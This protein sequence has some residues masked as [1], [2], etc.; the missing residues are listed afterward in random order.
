MTGV[1]DEEL[2]SAMVRLAE[3]P[4]TTPAAVDSIAD[5]IAKRRSHKR[6]IVVVGIAAA[7]VV[8]AAASLAWPWNR[9]SSDAVD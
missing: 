8:I 5:R 6:R 4:Q 1:D 7:V 2:R 3:P 9:G